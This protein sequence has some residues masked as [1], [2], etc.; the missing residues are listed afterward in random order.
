[1]RGCR[2]PARPRR[3]LSS[4]SLTGCA[5][6]LPS[7]AVSRS[8]T[9]TATTAI[10]VPVLA[11]RGWTGTPRWTPHAPWPGAGRTIPGTG[12]RW[13]ARSAT[14]TPRPGGPPARRSAG[15]EPDGASPLMVA[16]ADPGTL[17]PKTTWYLVTNL[18]R[19]GGPHEADSPHPAAALAEI[20]RIYGIRNWTRAKL[21]AGQGRAGLGRLP[22]PLRHRDP[23][24]PGPGQLRVLLLLGRLVPRPPRPPGFRSWCSEL[25]GE[26]VG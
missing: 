9:F 2:P 5:R 20:V 11:G 21:Q 19:P 13:C 15:W 12:A 16:T 18:P 1:M 25:V 26:S 23:P 17:P 14:G 24:P 7:A 3:R 4:S 8:S 10:A 6:R 22:G